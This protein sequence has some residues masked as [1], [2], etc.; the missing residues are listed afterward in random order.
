MTQTKAFNNSILD[1]FGL[2]GYSPADDAIIV[3]FRS[4]VSAQ[5]WIVNLDAAQV[6]ID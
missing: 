3:A 5:N 2:T 1:I 4:T 6:S